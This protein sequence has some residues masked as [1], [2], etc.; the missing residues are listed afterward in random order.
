MVI[1]I[2]AQANPSTRKVNI[3]FP[4]SNFGPINCDCDY[5]EPLNLQQLVAWWGIVIV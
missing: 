2:R 3:S 4:N 5:G 1:D